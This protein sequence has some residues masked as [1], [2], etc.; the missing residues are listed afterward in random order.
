MIQ[1]ALLFGLGFLTAALLVFLI[2][3]AIHRRIVWFTEKRLKA[4]MP[5]SPQEVRA[6]KDMARALFAAENARTEHALTQERDK[7]VSLQIHN[8][9]LQQE[10]SRLS[11]GSAELQTRIDDL[12]AEAGELRSRLRHEESYISQL[13]S[14]IHTAEQASAE[15]EADIDG[16]RKR[17]TKMAADTDNLKIDLATRET[18][19][20]SLKLRINTLRDERDTLRQD[21]SAANLRAADVGQSLRQESDKNKRL[22]ERLN[23]EIAGSADKETAIERQAQDV[24]RLRERLEAAVKESREA[25]KALRAAGLT[26]PKKPA[27]TP[28]LSA[29]SVIATADDQTKTAEPPQV[30]EPGRTVE[31]EIAEMTEEVRNRA[32]ALSDR[33]AKT[34]SPA[35]D[36][37]MREEIAKIAANMVALT[38]LKEGDSSPIFG[39]LPK[40]R[41]AAEPGARLSLADR[42][43]AMLPKHS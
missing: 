39:L 9:K 32:A 16:L 21:L 8:G 42:V 6:Q 15:K 3:P 33:L 18:E 17:M 20:E 26:P 11:A 1:F 28:K 24:I 14:G 22:E 5:L 4:T 34:R 25:S 29:A 7:T 41:E 13:K 30:A 36:D 43:A 37:A 40:N 31:D 27:R 23:R 38:A 35:H 19:I 12:E 2:A 10:A